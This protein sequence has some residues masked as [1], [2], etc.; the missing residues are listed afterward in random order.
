MFIDHTYTSCRNLIR[1]STIT[2]YLSCSSFRIIAWK[3]GRV[4]V[5]CLVPLSAISQFYRG[6]D[7]ENISLLRS[8]AQNHPRQVDHKSL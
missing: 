5:Y 3:K 2:D 1:L 4:V 6:G 7:T 8:L